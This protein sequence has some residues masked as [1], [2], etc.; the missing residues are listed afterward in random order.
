MIDTKEY[1]ACLQVRKFRVCTCVL[2]FLVQIYI[3]FG[4]IVS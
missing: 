1:T 2:M 3:G 4:H